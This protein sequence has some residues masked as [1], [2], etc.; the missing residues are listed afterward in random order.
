MPDSDLAELH[1]V[2]TKVLG[3]AVTRNSRRFLERSCFRL[4]EEEV[5]NLK[6]QFVDLL[7]EG[8]ELLLES[9]RGHK[10]LDLFELSHIRSCHDGAR[11]CRHDL[12]AHNMTAMKLLYQE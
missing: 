9:K 7:H 3:Q 5:R 2:E 6:S 8:R 11:A 12:L 1:R 10:H 4:T